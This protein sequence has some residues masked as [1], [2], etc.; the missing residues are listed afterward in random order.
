MSYFSR[1]WSRENE[2]VTL[3]LRKAVPIRE[4][5]NDYNKTDK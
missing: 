4:K 5:K 3:T 1:R 2:N